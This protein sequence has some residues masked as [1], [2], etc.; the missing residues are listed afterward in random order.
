MLHFK[1]YISRYDRTG[2]KSFN[3][4][5]YLS[6]KSMVFL[7]KDLEMYARPCWPLTNSAQPEALCNFIQG[8]MNF[9]RNHVLK[10]I[11]AIR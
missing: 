6:I 1:I 5:S 10:K 8:R 7:V 9:V 11:L 3:T 4:T 2:S